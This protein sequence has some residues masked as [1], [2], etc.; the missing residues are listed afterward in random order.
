MIN[1]KIFCKSGPRSQTGTIGVAR[2]ATKCGCVCDII[3]SCL[4]VS[5]FVRVG[6]VESLEF[7]EQRVDDVD[8]EHEVHL[9]RERERWDKIFA[10][11]I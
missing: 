3:S 5:V 6:S 9:H 8:K 1:R 10:K 7:V 2:T 11:N 4:P